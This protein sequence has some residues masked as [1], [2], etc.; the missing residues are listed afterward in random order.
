MR[1][2]RGIIIAALTY[3]ELVPVPGPALSKYLKSMLGTP[4]CRQGN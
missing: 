4:F 2:C 1:G 3:L